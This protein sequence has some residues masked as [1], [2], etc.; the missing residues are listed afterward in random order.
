METC[1]NTDT[2]D[3]PC[4]NETPCDGMP[5]RHT[6]YGEINTMTLTWWDQTPA[7]REEFARRVGNVVF[8]GVPLREIPELDD[9]FKGLGVFHPAW[10]DEERPDYCRACAAVT[11]LESLATR[12]AELE[13]EC[14][15]LRAP[16]H[17]LPPESA[18]LKD[19]GE[20]E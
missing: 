6:R 9:N 15:H 20:G 12:V 4:Q 18:A 7:S 13:D 3:L 19:K 1:G 14:R 10:H 8:D 2:F 17:W 5:H 11:K 16:T